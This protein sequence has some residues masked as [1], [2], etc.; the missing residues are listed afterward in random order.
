MSGEVEFK[1]NLMAGIVRVR[2][3]IR[4]IPDGLW[5]VVIEE[6]TILD[7]ELIPHRESIDEPGEYEAMFTPIDEMGE[8]WGEPVIV[9]FTVT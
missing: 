1:C 4:T 8:P 6:F 7:G 3:D 5:Q 2:L 9:P